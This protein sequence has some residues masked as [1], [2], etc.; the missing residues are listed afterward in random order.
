MLGT[1]GS[2]VAF[3]GALGAQAFGGWPALLA[4]MATAGIASQV[5]HTRERDY[6]ARLRMLD[7]LANDDGLE[8]NARAQVKAIRARYSLLIAA[9]TLEGNGRLGPWPRHVCAAVV[10]V[11]VLT[12]L[13]QTRVLAAVDPFTMNPPVA[14]AAWILT[15]A[16]T[17]GAVLL[18]A[19]VIGLPWPRLLFK[20]DGKGNPSH[21]QQL[22]KVRRTL[23]ND[24]RTVLK[25][26]ID[27]NQI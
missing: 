9:E 22:A 10:V 27:P 6:P 4:A 14:L 1:V 13:R 26:L 23:E 15:L 11:L 12:V 24:R 20:T 2:V 25:G 17:V 3:L 7:R 8:Q 19:A 5:A 16:A 21:R 18:L